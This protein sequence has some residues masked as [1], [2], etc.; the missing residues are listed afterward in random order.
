MSASKEGSMT[1]KHRK[2]LSE[3]AVILLKKYPGCF[4]NPALGINIIKG[5]NAVG[6]GYAR[7]SAYRPRNIFKRIFRTIISF[8]FPGYYSNSQIVVDSNRDYK[9]SK[10]FNPHKRLLHHLCEIWENLTPPE[11]EL[12]SKE[13]VILLIT[14]LSKLYNLNMELP[15]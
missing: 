5:H 13:L 1:K 14:K 4:N 2:L 9:T 11:K 12:K 7:H 15:K 8:L 10:L 3:M 6:R